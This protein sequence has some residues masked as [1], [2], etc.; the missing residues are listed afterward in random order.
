MHTVTHA[1]TTIDKRAVY[2][3]AALCREWCPQGESGVPSHGTI[4]ANSHL[5]KSKSKRA[6]VKV[7][8][9]VLA[10]TEAKLFGPL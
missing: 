8:H 4:T 2:R 9:T 10:C 7:G 3:I 5:E 1:T 6:K